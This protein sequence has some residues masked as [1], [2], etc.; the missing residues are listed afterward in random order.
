MKAKICPICSNIYPANLPQ[1]PNCQYKEPMDGKRAL[2]VAFGVLFL[3][4]FFNFLNGDNVFKNLLKKE[5]ITNIQQE[6]FYGHNEELKEETVNIPIRPMS[7]LSGLTRAEI[8]DKR[9]KYVK[10]SIIFSKLNN[11]YYPR[12]EVYNVVDYLPWISAYEVAKNGVKDNPDIG[13]G[14]SRHSIFVN[15]PELLMGFIIP[16]YNRGKDRKDF[17]E[18]DYMLPTKITWDEKNKTIKAYFDFSSYFK[19]HYYFRGSPFYLDET[20]ARDMGY[21]WILC[22]DKKRV[23]F[24]SVDNISKMPYKMRGYYH[25]GYGC[26]LESGCNNYSPHQ[27]SFDFKIMDS[28]SYMRFKFWKK[29]PISKFQK[30]DLIYEMYFE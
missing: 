14:A 5:E 22:D 4:L 13:V 20:N 18:V 9:I 2:G 21:D 15:N 28:D 6:I 30:A 29:K 16:D 26:R 1:C 19:K 7:S 12:E 8:Y 11:D 10:N 3:A 25:R 17:D 23:I 27:S 24:S